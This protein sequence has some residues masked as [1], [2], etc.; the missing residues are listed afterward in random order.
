LEVTAA[1]AGKI[2]LVSERDLAFNSIVNVQRALSKYPAEW[3][4]T[5]CVVDL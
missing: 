2:D 3:L 1:R 4:I 5:T